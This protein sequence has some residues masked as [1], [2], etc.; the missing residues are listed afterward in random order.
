[1]FDTRHDTEPTVSRIIASEAA[2]REMFTNS[3]LPLRHTS[4]GNLDITLKLRI[5]G[6]QRSATK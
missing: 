1:M 5:G 3:Y 4:A 2:S 6:Q